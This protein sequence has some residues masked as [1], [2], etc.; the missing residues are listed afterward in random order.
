MEVNMK[1]KVSIPKILEALVLLFL[2]PFSL[3][4]SQEIT[5]EKLIKDSAVIVIGK[6]KKIESKIEGEKNIWTYVTI[7]CKQY[8]KGNKKIEL[9]VRI[10]GGEVGELG[11]YVSGTPKYKVGEEVLSFLGQDTMGTYYVN[12]WENGK[13]TYKDGHWMQN[14]LMQSETF[15][16]RI[17]SII[18]S[19]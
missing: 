7:E 14:N 6:V 8:L 11:Q 17:K 2:I 10:P 4:Y 16:D 15:I 3:A 5:L 9:T 19:K 13:Y 1:Q 18:D 12:G